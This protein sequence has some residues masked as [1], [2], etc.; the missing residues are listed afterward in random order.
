M[1][2]ILL[3]IFVGVIFLALIFN[4]VVYYNYAFDYSSPN[5]DLSEI[6]QINGDMLQNSF[7]SVVSF[8]SN[9]IQ[10][11]NSFV[12]K[13]Y[14]WFNPFQTSFQT[15]DDTARIEQIYSSSYAYIGETYSTVK[16]WWLRFNLK[17]FRKFLLDPNSAFSYSFLGFK[18][19]DL[20]ETSSVYGISDTD[21]LWLH[22]YFSRLK[23]S[24]VYGGVTYTF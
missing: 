12:Y 24:H 18:I 21:K 8:S 9:L 20:E 15:E 4:Y 11:F 19:Y 17:S 1:S 7:R 14:G 10:I 2:K 23:I 6:S 13:I 16:A 22:D 3:Y 5:L